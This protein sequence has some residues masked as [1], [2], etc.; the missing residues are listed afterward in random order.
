MVSVTVVP[1]A[2][3]AVDQRA[4]NVAI[5]VP[6]LLFYTQ[7]QIDTALDALQSVG[8]TDIRVLVPWAAVEP[9]QGWGDWSAVDR[10]VNS[11]AAR[12]IKVLGVL[13]S[14]PTWAA[15]ENTLPLAGMPRDNAQFAAFAGLAATRYKGKVTAW[16]VWNEPN[17]ITVLAAHTQ[18]RPVHRAAEGGLHRPSRLPTRMQ[19]SSPQRSARWSTSVDLTVNPVRFISEMYQAGAAGYFDALSFHPYQYTTPF[20]PGRNLLRVAAQLR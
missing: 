6:D 1:P 15:V 19:S 10:V 12:N 2:A 20:Y 3:N 16:E 18:R 14:T 13:N 9:I 4:T 17:G 7:A 8:V 11:A 5:H